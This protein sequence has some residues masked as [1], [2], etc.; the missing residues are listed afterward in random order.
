MGTAKAEPLRRPQSAPPPPPRARREVRTRG[1]WGFATFFF[2]LLLILAGAAAL[3]YYF[4]HEPLAAE[5]REARGRMP[6]LEREMG[7]AEARL[8]AAEQER[9]AAVA[10]A[11]RLQGAHGELMATVQEREAQI[12]QLEAAQQRLQ[13]QFGAE[14]ASGDVHI[15]GGDGELSV[16]LA[17]QILFPPGE[18]ALSDGGQALLRRVASSLAQIEDRVIQVGGHTD[19]MRPSRQLAERFPTNWELSTARATNVVRFLTEECGIAGER[20][21]AA[22]FSQYRPAASNRSS[23]G[24]RRNRR[25]ELTLAPVPRRGAPSAQR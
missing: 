3:F 15:T 16:G 24:R 19:A 12:A 18:A 4:V 5:A 11:E 13:E 14:I 25:I 20:L 9:A 17:D 8:A 23:A 7:A 22:G 10:E 6:E 1:G 21:V 2:V